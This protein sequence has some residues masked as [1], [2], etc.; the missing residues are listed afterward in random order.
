MRPTISLGVLLCALW[1][2]ADEPQFVQ[3]EKP[4]S[5]AVTTSGC[6][7]GDGPVVANAACEGPVSGESLG[8]TVPWYGLQC[9]ETVYT[10]NRCPGGDYY[11]VGEWRH[12]HGG[13]EDPDTPLSD[14]YRERLTFDGNTWSQHSSGYDIVL[15]R[16][17]TV[18]IT[19]WYFCGDKPEIQN[20][21]NV[22]IVD[23]V[24]E[25]GAFG[26]E[27]GM[28]FGAD[29][30]KDGADKLLFQWSEG[31]NEGAVTNDIYCRIGT[32]LV[33]LRGGEAKAC[34]DPF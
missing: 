30:L 21:V 23:T 4:G 19:G 2:C 28:V 24:S 34:A 5:D 8:T 6:H 27:S 9:G 18:D 29:P 1:G 13:T 25:E 33:P 31:L 7:A 22:F 11:L 20:K 10:C 12:I 17:I 14:N 32:E 3:A 26:W 15:E 16:E